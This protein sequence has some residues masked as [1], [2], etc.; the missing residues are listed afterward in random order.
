MVHIDQIWD[1]QTP[2]GGFD[3]THNFA[4]IKADLSEGFAV[5]NLETVFGGPEIGPR[6]FPQFNTPDDA[7]G[8]RLRF[9]RHLQQPQPGL[10]RARAASHVG[11]A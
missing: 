1:A 11:R 9:R 5:G 10:V 7:Q 3:F 2:D 8:K 6:C 4:Q